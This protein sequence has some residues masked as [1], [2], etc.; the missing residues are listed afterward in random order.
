M[1][2]YEHLLS[3]HCFKH[4]IML[5]GVCFFRCKKS[6][7]C[8]PHLQTSAREEVDQMLAKCNKKSGLIGSIDRTLMVD[9]LDLGENGGLGRRWVERCWKTLDHVCVGKRTRR[10]LKT[11]FN[12]MSSK[13]QM[14]CRAKRLRVVCAAQT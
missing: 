13:K 5:G 10:G 11:F 9:E 8:V 2:K 7:V 12:E 6:A 4:F 1:C 3:Y 14:V